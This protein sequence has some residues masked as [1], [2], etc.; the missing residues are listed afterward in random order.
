[1]T[2]TPKK[3]ETV[4]LIAVPGFVS[5]SRSGMMPTRDMYK[6]PPLVN[7]STQDV[8]S[9]AYDWKKAIGQQQLTAD[10]RWQSCRLTFLCGWVG[11]GEQG[12]KDSGKSCC[13][14]ESS[15]FKIKCSQE[16]SRVDFAYLGYCCLLVV[17]ARFKKNHK[18]A[19]FV[20]N[21]MQHCGD[22]GHRSE[23][24]KKQRMES[25]VEQQR[26]LFG[27]G[28]WKATGQTGAYREKILAS[29]ALGVCTV[30]VTEYV[31]C[32]NLYA[33]QNTYRSTRV[34][35]QVRV[36]VRIRIRERLREVNVFLY[37]FESNPA[38]NLHKGCQ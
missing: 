9:P 6:K 18:I 25:Q 17:E 33:C 16:T 8:A 3:S 5:F 7:G 34:R 37:K 38:S 11:Q 1:M 23:L 10:G 31:P 24:W 13:E 28:V 27:L 15:K 36:R 4:C 20:R 35:I 19:D 30:P 21:L 26:W 22:Q 2:S 12:S 29:W 32:P 14:L